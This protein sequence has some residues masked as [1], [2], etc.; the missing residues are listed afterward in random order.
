MQYYHHYVIVCVVGAVSVETS[1]AASIS[2]VVFCCFVGYSV[3]A[4]FLLVFLA[5]K[6]ANLRYNTTG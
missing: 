6:Y 1:T 5:S 3:I 4:T 2:L